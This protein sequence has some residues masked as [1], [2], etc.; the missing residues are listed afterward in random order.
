MDMF[1]Q[2]P[3]QRDAP[4]LKARSGGCEE[5]RHA[6]ARRKWRAGPSVTAEVRIHADAE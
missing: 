2:N 3:V 6:A 1:P 4:R 5:Y